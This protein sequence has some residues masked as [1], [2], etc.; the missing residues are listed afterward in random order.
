MA[1]FEDHMEDCRQK[2]G[3]KWDARTEALAA[4]INH[5]ID[6]FAHTPSGGFFPNHR[7]FL[8]HTEGLEW[9][10]RAYGE[11]GYQIARWHVE[12]DC[13]RVPDLKEYTNGKVDEFGLPWY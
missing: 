3:S 2:M 4:E 6:Q 7:M 5:R 12:L 8:H 10:R 11:I 13:L 1:K 9:F